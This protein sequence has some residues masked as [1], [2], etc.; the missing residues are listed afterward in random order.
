MGMATR[1]MS[2]GACSGI[3]RGLLIPPTGGDP[4]FGCVDEDGASVQ[5]S[6]MMKWKVQ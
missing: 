2:D 3:K 4:G 6:D 5:R 1:N